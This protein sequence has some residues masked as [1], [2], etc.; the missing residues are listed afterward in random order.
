MKYND[1]ISSSLQYGCNMAYNHEGIWSKLVQHIIKRKKVKRK[2]SCQRDTLPLMWFWPL[3]RDH[4][5]INHSAFPESIRQQ[6][7]ERRSY[8]ATTADSIVR[9]F[10]T[11]P[12]VVLALSLFTVCARPS[13]GSRFCFSSFQLFLFLLLVLSF[14]FFSR[15]GRVP[16][17]CR[18][19][20]GV[21]F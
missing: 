19:N 6:S 18:A 4:L 16:K 11:R 15:T 20:S 10:M 3:Q 1:D 14:D 12:C 21:I 17:C 2:R 5:G 9:P 13:F 7:Q 8:T